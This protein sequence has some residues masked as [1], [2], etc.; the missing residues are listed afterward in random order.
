MSNTYSCV[1]NPWKFFVEK[2]VK[3]EIEKYRAQHPY[4]NRGYAKR[5]GEKISAVAY[6]TVWEHHEGKQVEPCIALVRTAVA[7]TVEEMMERRY[8]LIRKYIARPV[9]NVITQHFLF[10]TD[11]SDSPLA[12]TAA[13]CSACSVLDYFEPFPP[14]F[15]RGWMVEN[16]LAKIDTIPQQQPCVESCKCV[17]AAFISQCLMHRWLKASPEER[18]QIE[19][20]MDS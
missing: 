12:M 8:R 7:E 14:A 20:L 6:E 13:P 10:V 11:K 16:I 15:L 18:V 9:E 17:A 5:F 4:M 1:T 2:T 19:M 3:E